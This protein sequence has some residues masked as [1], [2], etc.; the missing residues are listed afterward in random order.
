MSITNVSPLADHDHVAS[1]SGRLEASTG[2][3][4]RAPQ[5]IVAGPVIENACR[6]LL[7]CVPLN[8]SSTID[9]LISR[10]PA[11]PMHPRGTGRSAARLWL[12]LPAG[13]HLADGYKSRAPARGTPQKASIAHEHELRPATTSGVLLCRTHS[14]LRPTPRRV[15]LE[16]YRRLQHR[17]PGQP[18]P[19]TSPPVDPP[20]DEVV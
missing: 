10:Y 11:Q 6:P 15:R 13:R 7:C 12:L 19:S 1:R 16:D 14:A 2:T 20:E 8:S 18:C 17:R 9:M 3:A 4:W 5:A